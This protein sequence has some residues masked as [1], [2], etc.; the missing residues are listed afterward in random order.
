MRNMSSS[1]NDPHPQCAAM[2]ACFRTFGRRIAIPASESANVGEITLY[3]RRALTAQLRITSGFK[4]G[5]TSDGTAVR[6]FSDADYA[7]VMQGTR[8]EDSRVL[9]RR[10][11]RIVRAT[12]PAATEVRVDSPAVSLRLGPAVW[13]R[14]ELVPVDSYSQEV[15]QSRNLLDPGIWRG[16]LPDGASGWRPTA[17]QR[18]ADLV[19]ICDLAHPIPGNRVI[20]RSLDETGG[21]R[22]ETHGPDRGTVTSSIRAAKGW[23][24]F[25]RLP[26]SSLYLL[27]A[28]IRIAEAHPRALTVQETLRR[29]YRLLSDTAL[30]PIDDPVNRGNQIAACAPRF[31]R[32]ALDCVRV[33]LRAAEEAVEAEGRAGDIDLAV[34]HWRRVFGP[35]WPL[36]PVDERHFPPLRRYPETT[37]E[38]GAWFADDD[39]ARTYM[40]TIRWPDGRPTCPQCSRRAQMIRRHRWRCHGCGIR[41]FGVE[42]VTAASVTGPPTAILKHLWQVSADG[43]IARQSGVSELGSDT[44]GKRFAQ[45]VQASLRR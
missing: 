42:N 5:S 11:R 31:Q 8:R 9:L 4:I 12:Y 22:S 30:A 6:G 38:F 7:L 3:L 13:H 14:I 21:I 44:H 15:R 24:Y 35:E 45:L 18:Y 16:L 26:I 29:L 1:K 19:D 25:N 32:R 34:D 40:E 10:L 2:A 27:L 28:T 39:A 43:S 36:V 41:S 23:K 20:I 37:E 33:S 17:P